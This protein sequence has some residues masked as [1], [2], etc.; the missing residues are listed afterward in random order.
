MKW[1]T[2]LKAAILALALA[3]PAQANNT[4]GSVEPIANSAVINTNPLREQ[5]LT[6]RE[7]FARRLLQCGIVDEVIAVLTSTRSITTINGLNTRFDVG[8]GGFAGETNPSFVYTVMDSGPNAASQDD[9]KVLTDSLA[10]VMSQGSAFLLDADNADSFDFPANY[11]VLNFA[12]PPSLAASAALFETVGKIDPLL[13]E[14]DSSGYTQYGR[15][16]LSLQSFVDDPQFIRGYF[17][18]AEKVGVEYTPIIGGVPGLFRGGAAFPSNDWTEF[19]RGE[20]YLARIPA[21]S[22]R[23]LAKLR[24]AHLRFTKSA[25]RRIEEDDRDD[26]RSRKGET[27]RRAM[28]QLA[29]HQ[30]WS[31]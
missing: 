25:L 29:C 6:V 2:V 21:Q 14:T 26:D 1:L 3:G 9:V 18:A 30:K 13:F 19:P 12:T 23:A 5:S 8:A 4:Y 15:A 20:D 22:H 11:V 10:Y 31:N 24:I 17:L 16:Y 28:S 27:L 7:V